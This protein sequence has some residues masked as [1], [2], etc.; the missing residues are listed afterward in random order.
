MSGGVLITGAAGRLGRALL[1]VL[2]ESAPVRALVLPGDPGADA[3][4]ASQPA[5][6][7]ECDLTSGGEVLRSAVDGVHTIYHLAALLPGAG[8]PSSDVYAATVLGTFNLL[9]AVAERTPTARLVYVSSTAVYGPQMPPLMDP[10]TEEHEIRPTSVYGAAKAAAETFVCAYSR[11]HGIRPTI[12]RP[13]DIVTRPDIVE[14]SGI[15]GRRFEMNER[16]GVIRVLVDESGRSAELSCASVDDIARGLA[17]ISQNDA[18]VGRVVHLGSAVTVSDS[19]LAEAI[20]RVK[21]WKVERAVSAGPARRWVIS[22]ERAKA[23]FGVEPG[24][25]VLEMVAGEEEA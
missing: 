1:T 21:G 18:A 14:P 20:A 5:V 19:E 8:V 3:L 11:S 4:R 17:S 16:D 2:G 25:S 24:R 10:I 7:L 9:E 6:V 15:V 23:E 12:I 13:T 22:V